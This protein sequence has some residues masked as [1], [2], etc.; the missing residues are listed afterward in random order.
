[1][2]GQR[3]RLL[4]MLIERAIRTQRCMCW[5]RF[6][7]LNESYNFWMDRLDL[8]RA[9]HQCTGRHHCRDVQHLLG[10]ANRVGIAR[11]EQFFACPYWVYIVQEYFLHVTLRL[12]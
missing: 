2:S 8:H 5:I 6:Q 3:D 10:N 4:E 12:L 11:Q 9:T 1:M 7:S